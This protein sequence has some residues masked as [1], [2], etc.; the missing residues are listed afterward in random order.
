M[1]QGD[2]IHSDPALLCGKPVVRGTRLSVKFLLELVGP[3]WTDQ[4][5]LDSYPR[6]TP[7]GLRAVR[8]RS[9][10]FS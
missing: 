6:L 5:I 10:E 1:G 7:E 4:Q 8:A 9:G 3:D 2:H